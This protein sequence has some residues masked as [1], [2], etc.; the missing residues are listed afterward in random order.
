M[1]INRKKLLI[2]LSVIACT[3]PLSTHAADETVADKTAA[4]KTAIAKASQNPVAAMYS[5]PVEMNFF[6]HSGPTEK[7]LNILLIKPVVPVVMKGDW[8]V[9][10]RFIIPVIDQEGQDAFD[11]NGTTIPAS[12]DESGLGNIQYTAF[13]SPK[14][15]TS[16]GILWGIG[17][18][19]ELPTASDDRLGPDAWSAGPSVVALTMRGK[20]V[21]GVLAQNIWDIEKDDDVADINKFTLQYFINYNLSNG[22]YVTSQPVITADWEA[23]SGEEWTIPFGGG[24]S[25]IMKYGKNAV[26]YRVSA[27]YNVDAPENATDWQFQLQ[28]KFLFPTNL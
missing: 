6:T 2:G 14:K 12:S 15:P 4:D 1:I 25:K 10:N 13:F 9:I 16:G 8:N 20:W 24:V 28:A 22:W 26:D 27:Y 17:P 11:S 5:I 23:D 19:I 7:D 21:F 18:V 3:L